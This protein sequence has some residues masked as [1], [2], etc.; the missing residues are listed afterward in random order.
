MP[1]STQTA[2]S[3]ALPLSAYRGGAVGASVDIPSTSLGE[4]SRASL[5]E[6]LVLSQLSETEKT[7][8]GS[9]QSAKVKE[10]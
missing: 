7:P 9:A 3:G 4:P 2:I 5:Y 1:A 8:L 10:Y 6:M